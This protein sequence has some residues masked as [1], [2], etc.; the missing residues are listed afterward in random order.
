M[1]VHRPSPELPQHLEQLYGRF[2]FDRSLA[3]DPISAIR[4]LARGPRRAEIAGIV[5]AT[6]AIGNT[7][8]IRG[9]I[10]RIAALA[11]GDLASWVDPA[12]ARERARRLQG[13]RHRWIRGDQLDH[14]F[15]VLTDYYRQHASLEDAFLA[16]WAT[17]G[18]SGGLAGL[19]GT[20]RGDGSAGRSPAPRGYRALFPS[21]FDP[22]ASACKRLTLFVRWMVRERYPDLG[23]WRRVPTGELRIPLDQH[24]HW[25]AYH[26]G[27]TARR[28]R[29]WR[30]VEEVTEALRR[31][32]PLDPVR[33]DF[34]LCHTGISGDCPKE[35]DLA[36]C[37]PCSVRP[38]CRL[39]RGHF[40]A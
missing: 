27:L 28:T 31:I 34:V 10:T 22:S 17:G 5:G 33:Y 4:P 36:V 29:N 8:A 32:D 39:W 21:P 30:T 19:A 20:L 11:E 9:A 40:A 6:L 38:D 26:L 25:I 24:V 13:F 3:E 16:G 2:P 7:T 23:I 35:R 14:L 15:R 37:G 12:T 1:R 18:F